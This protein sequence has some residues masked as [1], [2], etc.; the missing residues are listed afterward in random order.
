MKKHWRMIII[1]ALSAAALAVLAGCGGDDSSTTADDQAGDGGAASSAASGSSSGGDSDFERRLAELESMEATITVKS[2]GKVE[3]IWTSKGTNWRWDDPE[4]EN[5]YVIYR[6]DENK[7]WVVDGNTASEY[8]TGGSESQAW[9][10][11]NPAAM[12]TAFTEFSFGDIK[13]DVWEARFPMGSITIEFK[14]PEGLPTKM[15][16]DSDG[17]V[18]VVEFEYTNIGSV[19]DDLFELPSDVTVTVVPGLDDM[20][21]MGVEMPS[22]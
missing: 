2:D 11:K 20:Q 18:Q 4:D 21:G 12:I 16:V 8:S 22:S 15:T 19:S 5:S 1:V 17:D 9:M 3:S 6:G 10:G 14:G 7:F 13:D